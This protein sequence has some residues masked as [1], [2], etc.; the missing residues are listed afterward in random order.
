MATVTGAKVGEG[1]VQS[2]GSNPVLSLR[3]ESAWATV[4]RK[5][6]KKNTIFVLIIMK[7]NTEYVGSI[8]RRSQL[9]GLF[10]NCK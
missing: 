5:G 9:F 3:L 6:Q 8:G 2:T 4:F 10:C 1:V 7:Q